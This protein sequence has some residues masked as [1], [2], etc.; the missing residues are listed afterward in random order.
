VHPSLVNLTASGG[1]GWLGGFNEWVCRCGLASLGPPGVDTS[2]AKGESKLTLHGAIA[3]MPAHY[4]AVSA[5]DEGNGILALQGIVHE[6]TMFGPNLR[7]KSF[8]ST[9]AG[10]N[11]IT[12]VDEI[13]NLGDQPTEMQLMYH[14]NFGPPLLEEGARVVTAAADVVPIDA[15]AAR[16]LD[17]WDRYPG[18]TPGVAQD[19]FMIRPLADE[20]GRATVMLKNAAGD[21]GASISFPVAE[22]PCLTVWKH[23]GGANDGYVTGL[24]PSTSFPNFKTF[25]REQGRVVELEPGEKYRASI[26]I[27]VHADAESVAAMEYSINELQSTQSLTLHREPH[28]EFNPHA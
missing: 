22:L 10:S 8:I 19:V 23:P 12:I 21:I 4:V 16:S 1:L 15:H 5:V 25:E 11:S 20:L 3:N 17:R 24:E 2:E 28:P 6:A 13:T 7:L 18:P 14:S 9:V 26:V 27:T